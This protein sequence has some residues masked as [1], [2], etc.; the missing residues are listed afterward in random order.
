MDRQGG[1]Q[2][3]SW[4]GQAHSLPAIIKT[5]VIYAPADAFDRHRVGGVK[6]LSE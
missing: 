1:F 5:S 2:E 3:G 4:G 6:M